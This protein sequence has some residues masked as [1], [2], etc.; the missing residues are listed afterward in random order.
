MIF[1]SILHTI[2]YHELFSRKTAWLLLIPLVAAF[3]CK[4]SNNNV[5]PPGSVE[6]KEV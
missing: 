1:S 6:I 2:F 5:E 4:K 3:Y